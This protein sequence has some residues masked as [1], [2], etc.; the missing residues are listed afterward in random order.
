MAVCLAVMMVVGV[1]GTAWAQTLSTLR[2]RFATLWPA[3]QRSD[4]LLT[5]TRRAINRAQN[6]NPRQPAFALRALWVGVLLSS[7]AGASQADVAFNGVLGSNSAT[8]PGTSGTQTGRLLRNG[9]TTDSTCATAKE[10]PGVFDFGNSR[11]YDAYDLTN[12]GST[13]VCAS[14]TFTATSTTG[15]GLFAVAYSDSFNPA[16]ISQNYLSDPGDSAR[17][18]E[19]LTFTFSLAPGAKAVLVIHSIDPD[20]N[21]GSTYSV[22][23]TGLSDANVNDAPVATDVTLLGTQG[24]PFSGQLTASDANDGDTLTY[25]ITG[26]MLPDG[27]T[28]DAATGVVSGTPTGISNG[29]Q[30]TFTATDNQNATSNVATAT[31]VIQE[32]SSFMVDTTQDTVD[33]FDGFTSLREAILFANTDPAEDTILFDSSVFAQQQ[34]ITLTYRAPL[35]VRQGV[36]AA[37]P[38]T[39]TT[40][41]PL[42][43]LTAP[44][45]ISGPVF[46]VVVE[47]RVGPANA[48]FSISNGVTATVSRLAFVGSKTGVRNAGTFLL[49]DGGFSS[50]TTNLLNVSSGS[51]TLTNCRITGASTGIQN[52]GTLTVRNSTFSNNT[53]ALVSVGTANVQDSTLAS[54]G[55]GVLSNSSTFTLRNSTVVG[56]TH[57][58]RS[59]SGSA[60]IIQ[61][62]FVSNGNAVLGA[63]G[64]TL[65]VNRS[66]ISGN[67]T[68]LAR[69]APQQRF[70][71][72]CSLA[73]QRTSAA[74]RRRAFNLLNASAAQAG[75]ET[76]GNGAP[77]LKDNGGPTLTVALVAGSPVINKADPGISQGFDQRGEPFTRNADGRADIGAFEFQIPSGSTNTLRQAAPSAG[78]S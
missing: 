57:G 20:S 22:S 29:T 25:A 16:N 31:F 41:D 8:V 4:Q 73:T 43:P 18:G 71:T 47:G 37:L 33:A 39:G 17:S 28:L 1:L 72:A 52:N 70:A 15:E 54:N 24:N 60:N 61:S 21:V 64:V 12:T 68:D 5:A 74:P 40:G 49:T 45:I 23:V 30:V 53:N 11:A 46:G 35:T 63:S 65:L 77:L 76:D 13:T 7:M 56:N 48:L 14:V 32:D 34:T 9:F 78:A 59:Q 67:G 62:T 19:A 6:A 36:A 75:L 2:E 66:T 42:P 26:G 55:T 38:T 44:V 3:S 27:L 58:V 50:S 10:F 51:V 69:A